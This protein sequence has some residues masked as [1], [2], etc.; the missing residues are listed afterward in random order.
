[1]HLH[2]HFTVVDLFMGYN[3]GCLWVYHAAMVNGN[4]TEYTNIR[5]SVNLTF[6]V[7]Y[8]YNVAF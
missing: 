5:H 7:A 8:I 4:L 1:M 2:F 3:F 6:N